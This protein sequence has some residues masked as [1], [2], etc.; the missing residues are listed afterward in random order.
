MRSLLPLPQTHSLD[1]IRLPLQE[2]TARRCTRG[3][4]T[5][6]HVSPPRRTAPAMMHPPV[7][8][9]MHTSD[10]SFVRRRARHRHMTGCTRVPPRA[11]SR[12]GGCHPNTL[13]GSTGTRG[14][15]RR[16]GRARR[17]KCPPVCINTK[18]SAQRHSKKTPTQN[19]RKNTP[20]NIHQHTD[21]DTTTSDKVS[22][23]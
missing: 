19:A 9:R 8:R 15:V 6:N 10:H 14:L 5:L 18:A 22:T 23:T 12:H 20:I 3:F 13:C 4:Q 21:I 16:V 11:L 1:C 2:Q 7:R 17:R